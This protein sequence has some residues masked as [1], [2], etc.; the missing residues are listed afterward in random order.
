MNRREPPSAESMDVLL[1]SHTHWDREWYRTFEAFRAR[2]V[3]M[4]DRVL[5]LLDEDPGWRFLLDGQSII[6][7]DYL[8]VRPGERERLEAAVRAG[9]LA[10]GPWYVQ[11]DSLLPSGESHV[12]NLLEG[13]RVAEAFGGCSRVAYTPDSFGHPAQFPQLFAGFGLGPF[14]YW[15]GNGDEIDALGTVYRW[16]GPDG[17]AVLAYNLS[18]GYF[19]AANLP[20]DPEVAAESLAG[21]LD[22]LGPVE[23]APVVLMNG[24][25]HMF[26]D[27][28]TDAVADALAAR[29]GRTVYRGLLDDLV[30]TTDPADRAVHEGELLGG[31]LANLLPGVWSARLPLKLANRRAER[32]LFGW[33]EPWAALGAVLG[34][35]DESPSLRTA[36]RALL[37]NQAHDSIGGCSQDEVHRQMTARTATAVEL[38]EQTTKRILER[39]AG[40]SAQRPVPWS[41]DLDI[42]VFN[43]SP[44]P[45]TDVVA[46]ELDG[47]PMM[48]VGD[49]LFDVHPL[50]LGASLAAGYLADGEPV[51]TTPS[52]D[53]GRVRLLEDFPALDLELVVTDVPAFGWRRVS[54]TAAEAH[55]DEVD[56]A[57]T[58]ATDDLEVTVADD[59]T[60]TLTAGGHT[61]TGL[62][63]VDDIGDRGDTYDHDP[64]SD[65]PGAELAAVT[66]ERR[67]HPSGI[68]RLVVTRT[69][70]VPVGLTPDRERRA[71]ETVALTLRTEARVAPGVARV[72]L[73]VDLDDPAADH[74]LRL[75]FPTG[76]ETATFRTAT[77]FGVANRATEPPEAHGWL[78][79]PPPTFPHQGWIEANGLVVAAPGLP[80]GEVGPDGTIA[81][82]LLR[83]VGFL[84]HMD[85][86][87]RPLPAGPGLATPE[88]Q[89][90]EGISADLALSVEPD[91]ATIQADEL[92][93]RA[94]A[95]GE[96]PLL[97]SATPLLSVTPSVLVSALKPAEDGDGL[98]LRLL[99]PGDQPEPV[100]VALGFAAERSEVR[101]DESAGAEGQSE[102]EAEADIV[103]APRALRS[104]RLR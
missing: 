70:A 11:P 84:T 92:G 32:E 22:R 7:E 91:P 57:V 9:R 15:R 62:A 88:A 27:P 104:F 14:V 94:V 61:Y 58:I 38:A 56:E 35:T 2:L 6:V 54:L 96:E 66:V 47:F 23:R 25:D 74:R 46:V 75:L 21:V 101:L 24:V 49:D 99:N 59:G 28:H 90:R 82:T 100:T 93:L 37:A 48:Q 29:T 79:P 65:G 98:V 52:A 42:A 77:T 95:A 80:E 55:P 64:V 103:V 41:T 63:A 85:V 10:L 12:R 89:C 30:G 45:R 69:F 39:L 18:R 60:L 68:Q 72:D 8:T 78:H 16:A 50:S 83:S 34:L 44:F 17:S 86:R 20:A 19:A 97:P 4:V 26:P 31:R 51:R 73:H 5:D 33:A 40:L 3:D 53:P 81:V 13:R 67:R 71:D 1:V 76:A 102:D 87:T 43:P 36:R